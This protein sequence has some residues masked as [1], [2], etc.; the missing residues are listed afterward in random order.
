MLEERFIGLDPGS[1]EIAKSL[2][3]RLET[4]KREV[5]R[6]ERLCELDQGRA[7]GLTDADFDELVA[8]C[9]EMRDLWL[10]TTTTN[11]DRKQILRML[12]RCVTME[13]RDAERV[14]L[15]ISWIDGSP[16][17]EVGFTLGGY[18]NRLILEMADQGR[19]PDEI[20]AQ[21]NERQVRTRRGTPWGPLAITQK[22]R[23]LRRGA[24]GASGS[25][26]EEPG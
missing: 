15:T 7:T 26:A 24:A 9:S 5:R 19:A 1:T 14:G 17:T 21:L 16:P 13:Y 23:R 12:I 20:A 25:T 10:A 2:E 6:L 11:Q 3:A 8:L 22:L 4:A 18:V